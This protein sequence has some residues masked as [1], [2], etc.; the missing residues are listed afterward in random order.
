MI[1][2]RNH[3]EIQKAVDVK[4]KCFKFTEAGSP[5]ALIDTRQHLNRGS[6]T[7]QDTRL[8]MRISVLWSPGCSL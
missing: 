2:L 8:E 1:R 7:S 3:S 5:T 4:R 6:N